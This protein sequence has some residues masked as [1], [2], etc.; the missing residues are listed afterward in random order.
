MRVPV[1]AIGVLHRRGE[2]LGPPLVPLSELHPFLEGL[3]Q[4][5]VKRGG[6]LS[7]SLRLRR[8]HPLSVS[9]SAGWG[10]FSILVRVQDV[11]HSPPL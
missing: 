3:L 2:V 10:A 4:V 8:G 6:T 7:P 5:R 11:G 1:H 9:A